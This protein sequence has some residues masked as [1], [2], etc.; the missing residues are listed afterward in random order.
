M[1]YPCKGFKKPRNQNFKLAFGDSIKHHFC[2]KFKLGFKIATKNRSV[3][4]HSFHKSNLRFY[5]SAFQVF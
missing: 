1:I 3:L 5:C 4:I 2:P